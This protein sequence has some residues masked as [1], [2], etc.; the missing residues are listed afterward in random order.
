MNRWW[1][2]P[3]QLREAVQRYGTPT[4]AARALGGVSTR[5]V[6]EA[7]NKLLAGEP[8][9]RSN[10]DAQRARHLES[11]SAASS[12]PA[13]PRADV[14][15]TELV[16][17]LPNHLGTD[18]RTPEDV[19]RETTGTDPSDW[20][21][22]WR[23]NQWDV[24]AGRNSDGIV[25]LATMHQLTVR[26]HRKPEAYF[27]FDLPLGWSPAPATPPVRDH[28]Q[29]SLIPIFADPHAPN[30]QPELI[31]ASVRWLE[32][33][34]PER[35]YCIGDAGNN[36]PF[37][38][39]RT[40]MRPDLNVTPTE[41]VWSTTELLCR[42]AQASAGARRTLLWG[43][44][45]WWLYQRV[46]E[47]FPKLADFRRWNEE[48]PYL[49]MSKILKLDEIGWESLDTLGEYHDVTVELAPELV[50]MHG[51]RTGIHG[52]A[53]KEIQHWEG[54]SVMQGHDHRL[55]LVAIRYRL[56]GGRHVQRYAISAGSMA[57]ADLG[58]DTGHNVGQGW[59]VL[60]LWPD[61]RWGVDFALYCPETKSTT[62]RDW[63]HDA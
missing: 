51:T 18:T 42:W 57:M 30:F 49:A 29:P 11:S 9:R 25:E 31:E 38:R 39:H 36:S 63:R 5:S 13:Q 34:Q 14:S 19:V 54:A 15:D 6:R 41:A 2:D 62:W 59:P 60:S 37:G 17:T 10:Q 53:A 46:I 26:A 7:W 33:F 44:H 56:A 61:G 50:G 16:V 20:M 55:A 21:I 12:A 47:L 22:E 28:G 58:Y 52:G 43:N 27:Q 48:H 40:N 35:I 8:Q 1:T 24:N 45:D 32:D 23:R 3:D 4:A